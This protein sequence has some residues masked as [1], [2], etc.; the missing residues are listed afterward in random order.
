MNA[1]PPSRTGKPGQRVQTWRYGVTFEFDLR[2]PLTHNGLVTASS[3]GS[4]VAR[5]T[6]TAHRALRPVNVRSMVCVL[7]ER[8]SGA[9]E[10]DERPADA[11]TVADA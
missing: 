4:L 6:K 5:A 1:F 11:E 9:S 3:Y 7:L 8:V 2:P 10:T